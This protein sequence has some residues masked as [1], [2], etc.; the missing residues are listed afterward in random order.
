MVV[1]WIGRRWRGR[2]NSGTSLQINCPFFLSGYCHE[3][4]AEEGALAVAL[5]WLRRRGRCDWACG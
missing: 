1:D 3:R 4:G 5:A 2:M